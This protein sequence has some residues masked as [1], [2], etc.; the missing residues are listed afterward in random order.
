MTIMLPRVLEPE[1]M[2]TDEDAREYDAMDHSVVNAQFVTDLLAALDTWSP[3]TARLQILDL[4]VGTAQ[5]PIELARRHPTA[6]ITA[7]D[8][9]PSMLALARTNVAAATLSERIEAIQAD[10]KCLPFAASSFPV[11]ISNSIAHHIPEPLSV[12]KEAVR[13]TIQGGFLFH[14]DL[15]RP[16]AERQLM[17]LVDAYAGKDT[18]YQRQLFAQSLQ[19]AL[20]LDEVRDLVTSLGFAGKSVQMTSDRHWTWCASKE[21]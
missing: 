9:A 12:F 19:A 20:S 15:A 8:A 7:V 2:N 18:P 17:Q 4:G 21:D 3:T 5:I 1:V 16:D 10:A 13:V 6:H 11:V 14:R